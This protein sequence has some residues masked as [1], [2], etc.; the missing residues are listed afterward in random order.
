MDARSFIL[1]LTKQSR[2]ILHTH[3][4]QAPKKKTNQKTK[5]KAPAKQELFLGR[6]WI[7]S[8]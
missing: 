1:P 6:N 4:K 7:I 5:R 2:N 8:I 3:L